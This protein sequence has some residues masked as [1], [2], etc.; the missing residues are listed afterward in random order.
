[1]G[2]VSKIS[3]SSMVMLMKTKKI[4]SRNAK[5]TC[6]SVDKKFGI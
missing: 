5:N 4:F 6:V 1:M 2:G 3:A